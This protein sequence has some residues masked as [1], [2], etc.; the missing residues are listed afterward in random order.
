MENGIFQGKMRLS[1]PGVYHINLTDDE[2]KNNKFPIQYQITPVDDTRPMITINEP[3]RDVRVNAVEEVFIDVSVT[4][5]FGVKSTKI[6]YSVNGEDEK[7]IS[8]FKAGRSRKKEI[9][10]NHLFYLEDYSLEPGDVI[11]YYVDAED[12]F[13]QSPIQSDMYWGLMIPGR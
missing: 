1:E 13:H 9:N 8:L 3:Q 10:G 5:D 11:S 12:N 2:G 4:D 6:R 7:S